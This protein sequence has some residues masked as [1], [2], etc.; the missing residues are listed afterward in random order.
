MQ[1]LEKE[2]IT[3]ADVTFRLCPVQVEFEST[4]SSYWDY[5]TTES[6]LVPYVQGP[7]MVRISLKD[8]KISFTFSNQ[9][10]NY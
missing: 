7:A 10:I 5:S 4:G 6:A 1:L 2:E 9:T 3:P 8:T